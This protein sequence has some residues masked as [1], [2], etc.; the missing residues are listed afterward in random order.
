MRSTFMTKEIP[1][2]LNADEAPPL[3]G[4]YAMAIKQNRIS[5]AMNMLHVIVI[6]EPHAT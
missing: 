6:A 1:F 2:C 3:P 4:A 5:W